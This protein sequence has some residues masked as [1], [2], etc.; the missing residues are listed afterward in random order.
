M[1][2][3]LKEKIIRDAETWC[4]RSGVV[5]IGLAEPRITTSPDAYWVQAWVKVSPDV[6]P[7]VTIIK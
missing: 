2:K 7:D 5:K 3:E 4:K 1:K 6:P